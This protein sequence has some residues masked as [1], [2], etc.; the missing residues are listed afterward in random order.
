MPVVECVPNFSEGRRKEVIEQI[1]DA[2]RAVKGVNLLGYEA[3]ADHN[4]SVF[5]IAGEPEPVLE[6]AFEGWPVCR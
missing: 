1:A 3:D 2:I 4:R 5:T 6:A